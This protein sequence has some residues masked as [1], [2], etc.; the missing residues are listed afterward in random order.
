MK[1]HFVTTLMLLIACS[2]LSSCAEE[3]AAQKASV[4]IKAAA[5]VK[6]AAAGQKPAAPKPPSAT[7]KEP[8]APAKGVANVPA[9]PTPDGAKAPAAP[10]PAQ[11][12]GKAPAAPAQTAAKAGTAPANATK[13]PVAPASAQGAAKVPG[14]PP[15]T[16]AKVE[17]PPPALSVPPGYRYE[18]RGRR[19]PFVNPIP[20]QQAGVQQESVPLV[21]PDGLPG[22]LVSEVKLSGIV[23]SADKE[24]NKVMLVV[25]K[26]TYFAKKGDR[27]F[28][29]VIKEI[30][31]NEVVFTMVS[32]TTRKPV[33]RDTVVRTG[34][35]S[36]TSAG[37]KK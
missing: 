15:Q 25:G 35:S 3:Q 19:D 2:V 14:T 31:P 11:A 21:R 32:A 26:N 4:E 34:G 16:A 17:D 18:P 7:N 13:A 22:V 10:G 8:A 27:L 23:H 24:M 30:R 33:N 29:G 36:G 6:P 37:E 28:D 20:R 1:K 12:A 9:V 5:N